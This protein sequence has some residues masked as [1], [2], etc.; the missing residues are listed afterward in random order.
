MQHTERSEV[1]KHNLF[2]L[3]N[4]A[5]FI[6]GPSTRAAN[7]GITDKQVSWTGFESNSNVL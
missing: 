4:K 6:D 1:D 3:G 5:F 2:I 7:D